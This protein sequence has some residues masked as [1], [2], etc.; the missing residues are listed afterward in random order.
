MRWIVFRCLILALIAA[1]LLPTVAYAAE[2]DA[3][4][5]ATDVVIVGKAA[6]NNGCRVQGGSSWFAGQQFANITGRLG[7]LPEGGKRYAIVIGSN[8]TG[9]VAPGEQIPFVPPFQFE[10]GYAEADAEAMAGLLEGMY[11]FDKVILL[12]GHG[13]SQRK[14]LNS[15]ERIGDLAKHGD[16]V[17]FFYSGHGASYTDAHG[18]GKD[19]ED[20]CRGRGVTHEGIVTDEGNGK[21]VKFLWDYELASAF[22]EFRTNRIV[23]M[24]DGCLAGGMT[25]LAEQGRIV[26]MATTKTGIAAEAGIITTPDGAV[27]EINHGLFTFFLLGALSGDVTVEEAFNFASG[28]LL[29]MTLLIQGGIA[30][31]YGP[32]IAAFWGTPTIVD[33]FSKDLL[34]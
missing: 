8:Y 10:L 9:S 17:V 16:E 3:E 27:I 13:A 33:L 30:Y 34:L 19:G 12:T 1:F 20:G 2:P 26:C 24:F 18:G 14:I 22:D 29:D 23:F 4:P 11:G 32:E 31:Y 21:E 15:I 28:S 6:F 7:V 5:R 25:E